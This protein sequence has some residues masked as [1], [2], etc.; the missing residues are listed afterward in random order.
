MDIFINGAESE[1]ESCRM[2]ELKAFDNTK[3]GVKGLVDAGI[4]NVPNM[5]VRSPK[6]LAEDLNHPKSHIGLPLIDLD[7]LSLT[8]SHAKI[9]DQVRFAS[10]EWGFFQVV[11][12]G[13]PFEVLDNMLAGI[14]NFNEQDID[15]KREL[16]TR[17]RKRRVRFNSNHDLFQ[18]QRA[19]WRDTL[20]V[21]MLT[22]DHVDPNELPQACRYIYDICMCFRIVCL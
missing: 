22:S 12:H 19:D 17:D 3:L 14:R 13:I 20:S 1:L 18:S 4:P 10:E 6:E 8:N 11:N 21:S 9:A 7:C 16:Y 2:K 5:F 15:A